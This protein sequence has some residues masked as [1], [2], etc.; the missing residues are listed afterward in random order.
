MKTD[1]QDNIKDEKPEE[2]RPKNRAG[3]ETAAS[4]S[5]DSKNG[6]GSSHLEQLENQLKEYKDKYMRLVA[7]FDNARKRMERDRQ[8]FVKYANEDLI[9]E[10]LNILDN[11]ELSVKSAEEGHQD[12]QG[13]VKGLEL[14][15]NQLYELLKKNGVKPIKAVGKPFDPHCQEVLFQQET[16]EHEDGI[17]L[18]EF[19]KGYFLGE[20]VVRTAKVKVA[21]RNNQEVDTQE[22]TE[23]KTES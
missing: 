17:V 6:D 9:V 13:L 15:V 4:G 23:D 18:E 5:D 3:A 7:E 21:T 11:L 12:K 22:I 8:E 20:R 10:F 1:E 14:V 16:T 2:S 19:Q